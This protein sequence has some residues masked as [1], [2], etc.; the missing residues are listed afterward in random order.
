MDASRQTPSHY[1]VR[2]IGYVER[3]VRG[4]RL[5]VLERYRDGLCELDTFSHAQVLWWFSECDDERSR[6]ATQAD[7]PFDAPTLGVFASRAPT[8]PNPVAL[9]TVAIRGVD[10]ERGTI[11][12]GAIDAADG[13]PVLDI[14]PYMPHY[15]RPSSP[16]GQPTGLIGCRM[17]VSS[18]MRRSTARD[19]QPLTRLAPG[20]R[21]RGVGR[22]MLERLAARA[23]EAGVA[24]VFLWVNRVD[25]TGP[26]SVSTFSAGGSP[27]ARDVR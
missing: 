21:G 25:E 12:I 15:D 26:N 13:S 8:R 1:D 10:V 16:T 17:M 4:V 3:G 5:H 14:K 24:S 6:A 19:A 20:W 23:R 22:R 11:D 2:R 18:W 27:A 9:S 7:P